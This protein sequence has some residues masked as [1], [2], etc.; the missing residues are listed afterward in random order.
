MFIET[1]PNCVVAV[2]RLVADVVVKVDTSISFIESYLSIT[3]I[4]LPASARAVHIFPN[5]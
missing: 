4:P 3:S 2:V 5:A 1:G